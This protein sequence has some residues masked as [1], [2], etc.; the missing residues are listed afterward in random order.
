MVRVYLLF[1]FEMIVHILGVFFFFGL[2]HSRSF[3]VYGQH[4][5]DLVS[6]SVLVLVCLWLVFIHGIHAEGAAIKFNCIG[7]GLAFF[8]ESEEMFTVLVES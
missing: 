3:C 7:S 4:P 2:R 8:N 5:S 6:H 1:I